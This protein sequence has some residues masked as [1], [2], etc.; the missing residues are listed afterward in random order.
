[1]SA[2]KKVLVRAFMLPPLHSQD[3]VYFLLI[4]FLLL[5]SNTRRFTIQAGRTSSRQEDAARLR[6]LQQV[7]QELHRAMGRAL[8]ARV[9]L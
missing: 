3:R 2:L 6:G 9:R 7:P 1:M 4:L 8:V 5:K